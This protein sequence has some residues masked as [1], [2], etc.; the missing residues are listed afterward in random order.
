MFE[1]EVVGRD[2]EHVLI[3]DL[4]FSDVQTGME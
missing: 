1:V 4:K 3:G 2:S